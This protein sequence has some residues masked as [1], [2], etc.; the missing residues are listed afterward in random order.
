M[1][2]DAQFEKTFRRVHAAAVRLIERQIPHSGGILH[3]A[4][5]L[6][7]RDQTATEYPYIFR[8]S[9]LGREPPSD[10]MDALAAAIHLLQTSTFVIDDV[11]DNSDERNGNPTV[12]AY[13]GADVAIV[14]GQILQAIAFSALAGTAQARFPARSSAITAL[15][16]AVTL[17]Y[18]GQY[19]DL[20][21]S[22]DLRTS[23]SAYYRTI[24][25][26]TASLF[27]GVARCGALFAGRSSREIAA[28]TSFGHAYGMA[29]QVTDDIL[30]VTDE[31]TG[32]TFGM[33]LRCRRMR[34]PFIIAIEK[35]TPRDRA[36]LRSF[37]AGAGHDVRKIRSI[38]GIIHR[39]GAIS[40]ALLI[41]QRYEARCRASLTALSPSPQ[42][43]ALAWLAESLFRAQGLV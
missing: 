5:R 38:A 20:R 19:R 10:V 24:D 28:L 9:F 37:V 15:S 6:A 29:L 30:D 12:R 4:A 18:R 8:N 42:R 27:A 2:H 23:R 22:A 13:A 16:D 35:A 14:V 26:T 25:L 41:A 39:S 21:Y 11:F 32:K 40:D 17:V 7:L 1:L 33:D 43:D 31:A 34:L 36:T 3:T